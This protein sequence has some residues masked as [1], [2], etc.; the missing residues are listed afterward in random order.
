LGDPFRN[1]ID[2]STNTARRVYAVA[3]PVDRMDGTI[4]VHGLRFRWKVTRGRGPA[5]HSLSVQF[6]DRYASRAYLKPLTREEAER[7]AAKLVP[8]VL[9]RK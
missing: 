2:T 6:G 4:E 8:L 9:R 3:R 1:L 5:R 7:E